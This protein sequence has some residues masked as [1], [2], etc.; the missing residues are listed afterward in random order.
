[1]SGGLPWWAWV[2]IVIF[3]FISAILVIKAIKKINKSNI[4]VSAASETEYIIDDE[5]VTDSLERIRD[6][7]NKAPSNEK[8]LKAFIL[9]EYENLYPEYGEFRI[10]LNK[11]RGV[12]NYTFDYQ[13]ETDYDK[14]IDKEIELYSDYNPR[15]I[16]FIQYMEDKFKATN[17]KTSAYSSIYPSSFSSYWLPIK[18]K[19]DSQKVSYVRPIFEISIPIIKETIKYLENN[20]KV[21]HDANSR[22][23]RL[24]HLGI[25]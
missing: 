20:H 25:L 10:L 3:V 1:M 14:Y 4:Q 15:I 16:Y 21:L 7:Y 8:N 19:L 24:K 13:Q 22:I 17:I 23:Q 9:R 6:N 5:W 18:E 11:L 2:L 12:C